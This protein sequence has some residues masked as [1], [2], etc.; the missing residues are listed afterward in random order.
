LLIFLIK[1][2]ITFGFDAGYVN[3]LTFPKSSPVAMSVLSGFRLTTFTSVP[4]A[5]SGQ[6]PIVSK[7][8]VHEFVAHS[9]S[10]NDELF[11]IWRQRFGFPAKMKEKSMK[12]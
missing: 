5:P 12:F 1:I 3:N 4:S 11:V 2:K 10:R 7:E 6:I 9:T 8:I